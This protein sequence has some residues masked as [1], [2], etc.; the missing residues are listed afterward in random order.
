[1]ENVSYLD[2]LINYERLREIPYH[3]FKLARMERLSALLGS[4]HRQFRSVLV[5][6][7]KGKGSTCALAASILEA[8]GHRVGLYTSPHLE[9][10]RERIQVDRQWISESAVAQLVELVRPAVEQ[11]QREGPGAVSF[12]EVYTALAFL[13]FAKARV[14]WAVCEVGLGG[15]L[16]ATNI[17]APEACAI[18]PIS[19]DHTEILGSTVSVI[20]REKAGIVKPGSRVVIAPQR[21]EAMAVIQEMAAQRDVQCWRVGE[22]I[23]VEEG[24]FNER[25]QRFAV[26]GI[27]RRYDDLDIGLLGRHQLDNAAVAIGLAELCGVDDPD[28]IRRGLRQTVWPGRMEVVQRQPLIVLDGAQNAASAT[29]LVAGLK[30]HLS[31]ERLWLLLGISQGKDVDGIAEALCPH[32]DEVIATQADN[33]RVFPADELA[34][35]VQPVARRPVRVTSMSEAAVASALKL[36]T[37]RDAIIITGSLYL[38]GEVRAMLASK[39]EPSPIF[40]R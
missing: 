31:Y 32:A 1:M 34:A 33:P 35:R 7:T 28:A 26:Q 20:A 37:P 22:D 10:F 3:E 11:A 13:Y 30:R 21:P 8:A 5:A 17:L 12:F 25:G 2:S 27:R 14:D 15:R 24:E 19:L 29:A 23:R 6:G 9:S 39:I 4:P 40:S 38:V 36:A 18:T 16:D